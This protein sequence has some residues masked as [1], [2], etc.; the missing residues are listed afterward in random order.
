MIDKTIDT[1]DLVTF[2]LNKPVEWNFNECQEA[3]RKDPVAFPQLKTR[4]DQYLKTLHYF[5]KEQQVET[6]H[7]ISFEV[8]K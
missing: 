1:S 8:T 4:Y 7:D 3:M 2:D 5:K 6:Q